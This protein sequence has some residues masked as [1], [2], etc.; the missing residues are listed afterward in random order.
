MY[1]LF[2]DD[3]RTPDQVKWIKLPQA[4]FLIVRYYDSFVEYIKKNG[5]PVFITF[6]HDL[7]KGKDGYACAKWLV[8]YC[9][10]NKLECPEFTSHSMNPVGKENIM[11]LLTAFRYGRVD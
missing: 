8:N 3:E 9:I 6:D 2:L 11:K 4:S 1:H 7:G 10:S 5:L